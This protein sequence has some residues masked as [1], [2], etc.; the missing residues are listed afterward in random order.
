M[1]LETKWII[2]NI[3]MIIIIV[4]TLQDTRARTHCK[5]G[6]QCGEVLCGVLAISCHCKIFHKFNKIFQLFCSEI[7]EPAKESRKLSH[8]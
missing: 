2:N 8:Y 3:Y 7:S 1:N 5:R 4:C 6:F